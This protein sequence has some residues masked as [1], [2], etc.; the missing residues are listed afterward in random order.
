MIKF[1][2]FVQ[3]FVI[4][5]T[6]TLSAMIEWQISEQYIY[7]KTTFCFQYKIIKVRFHLFPK[8]NRLFF[9]R[10]NSIL[11]LRNKRKCLKKL[12]I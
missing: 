7:K 4:I 10:K 11:W 2:I 12:K 8:K 9:L 6:K 3:S 1:F 5:K